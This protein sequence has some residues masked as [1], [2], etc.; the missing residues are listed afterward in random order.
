M[1][2]QISFIVLVICITLVAGCGGG[3]GGSIISP[4]SGDTYDVDANG[5][6]KFVTV[7]YIELG[8]IYR[9]SKF[10]SGEGHYYSDDF[11]S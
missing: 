4:Y 7:D 3:D 9:I 6:P 5:I 10:R 8:K 11:E 1:A 2:K